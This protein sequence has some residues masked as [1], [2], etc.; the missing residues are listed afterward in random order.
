M[1]L[2]LEYL[3]FFQLTNLFPPLKDLFHFSVLTLNALSV[4][5]LCYKADGG[6]PAFKTVS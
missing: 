5:D 6:S 3:H 4:Y 1:R 2:F